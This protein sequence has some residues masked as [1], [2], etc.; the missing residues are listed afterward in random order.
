M[1]DNENHLSFFHLHVATVRPPSTFSE[2]LRMEGVESCPHHFFFF[3]H[4]FCGKVD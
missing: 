4:R 2:L 1:E 3:F